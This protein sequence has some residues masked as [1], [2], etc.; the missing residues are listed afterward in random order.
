MGELVVVMIL[1]V[2]IVAVALGGL[3]VV[4]IR[5][6]RGGPPSPS[7]SAPLA[8]PPVYVL[9]S[10]RAAAPCRPP[11]PQPPRYVPPGA[12]RINAYGELED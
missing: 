10:V 1:L 3:L 11:A 5:A 7:P 2:L 9:P 12:P 6:L 4:L 8:A